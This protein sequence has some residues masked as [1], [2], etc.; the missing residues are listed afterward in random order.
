[1]YTV[2]GKIEQKRE[3]I[4]LNH[5]TDRFLMEQMFL[6]VQQVDY[7]ESSAI[8]YTAQ[9]KQR[10][11]LVVVE[12]DICIC[13]DDDQYHVSGFHMI[14]LTQLGQI[15]VSSH[16]KAR[17]YIIHYLGK[18]PYVDAP[19]T[20]LQPYAS[21]SRPIFCYTFADSIAILEIMKTLFLHYKNQRTLAV[22][23][24]FQHLM[25]QIFLAL[26]QKEQPK[27]LEQALAYIERHLHEPIFIQEIAHHVNISTQQLFLLFQE[28]FA[29][30]P[31]QYIQNRKQQLAKNYLR[32]RQYKVK[33]VAA[34]LHF[35]NENEF[36][37]FFKQWVAYTPSEF[38]EK[39]TLIMSENPINNEN[40]FHYNKN[41]LA[42]AIRLESRE[43]E[44]MKQ[45]IMSTIKLPFIFSLLVILAACSDEAEQEKT[46]DTAETGQATTHIVTDGVG[47]EVE[48]P[49]E[50]QRIVTDQYLEILVALDTPPVGA[51]EH[52]LRTDYMKDY[53]KGIESIGLPVNM[54]SVLQLKPDL[55]I[56][57]AEPEKEAEK[58]EGLEKIAPTVVVPWINGDDT[59]A[60]MRAVATLIGK[61]QQADEW[62]A[63]LEKKGQEAQEQIQGIIGEDETVTIIVTYG[64]EQPI[65][66]GGR[67][68]GHVF[69]RLLGLNPTPYIQEKIKEDPNFES[70]NNEEISIEVLPEYVGDWLIVLDYETGDGDNGKTMNDIKES[71]IWKNL[72]AVKNNRVIYLPQDPFFSYSPIAIEQSLEPAVSLIKEKAQ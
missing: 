62:I 24:S 4:E 63:N 64:K 56:T 70:F 2:L 17:M 28:R 12:G 57:T 37:R 20:T 61:E 69:Y 68:I 6:K 8:C 26:E 53:I 41:Q 33:D 27:A 35:A 46:M 59:Y 60:Q 5:D 3:V 9:V 49:V 10:V 67:N 21:I 54:E 48:I 30:S 29:Q 36:S 11:W 16:S 40:H 32:Q 25:A 43:H 18:I 44:G 34:A 31:K 22:Q 55:I 58:L 47:R 50:P 13:F 66:Y 19:L 45:R 38:I 14:H 39:S 15:F 51:G 65:I 52:V 7:I 72:E 1:M 23:A 71:A 42:Q